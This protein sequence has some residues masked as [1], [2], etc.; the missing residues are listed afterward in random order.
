MVKKDHTVLLYLFY[1]FSL[2]KQKRLP[3]MLTYFCVSGLIYLE[4]N[5]NNYNTFLS[6]LKINL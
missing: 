5:V 3:L 2:L 4:I 1:F 6:F